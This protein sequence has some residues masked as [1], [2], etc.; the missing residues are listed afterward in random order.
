MGSR[1]GATLVKHW[2]QSGIFC[3]QQTEQIMVWFFSPQVPPGGGPGARGR[4]DR[5]P[6]SGARREQPRPGSRRSC[7]RPGLPR[8]A[9]LP[10]P[11]QG[12]ASRSG[13]R[14]KSPS[15]ARPELHPKEEAAPPAFP[16]DRPGQPEPPAVTGHPRAERRHLPP[17]GAALL[18]GGGRPRRG[19]TASPRRGREP[20]PCLS[21]PRRG[22]GTGRGEGSGGA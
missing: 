9:P 15:P 18:G 17:R 4:L 20:R 2:P 22:R 14:P 8:A 6:R 16:S 5:P 11:T 10:L 3:A 12:R 7:R 19:D 21:F 1:L 13:R